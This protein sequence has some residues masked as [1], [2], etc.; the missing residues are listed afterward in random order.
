MQRA[1]WK[2]LLKILNNVIS[3]KLYSFKQ[4]KEEK[5]FICKKHLAPVK[6]LKVCQF[7]ELLNKEDIAIGIKEN[8]SYKIIEEKKVKE[9][10]VINIT[11]FSKEWPVF[12]KDTYIMKAEKGFEEQLE[13]IKATMIKKKINGYGS[14]Y[15][16]GKKEL[17]CLYANENVKDLIIYV[18]EK[19]KSKEKKEEIENIENAITSLSA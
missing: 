17:V 2:G 15:M 18:I 3:V 7:G 1:S 4:D 16:H 19:I 8:G 6:Y 11:K 12:I 10:H 13:K 14:F 5:N 9:E